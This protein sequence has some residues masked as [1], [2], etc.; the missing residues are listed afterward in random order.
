MGDCLVE[1]LIRE[2]TMEEDSRRSLVGK[3]VTTVWSKTPTRL[4]CRNMVEY[5]MLVLV[6]I[7]SKQQLT[8]L[9]DSDR[10]G[11]RD[12][13]LLEAHSS[14]NTNLTRDKGLNVHVTQEK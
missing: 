12:R 9:L 8:I 14:E 5:V 6:K 13:S 1:G 11:C 7:T 3:P 4:R 2:V 10:A